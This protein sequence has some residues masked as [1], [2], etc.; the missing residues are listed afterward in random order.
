M[1]KIIYRWAPIMLLGIVLGFFVLS[2]THARS[3]GIQYR[4]DQ[5]DLSRSYTR[6]DCGKVNIASMSI[7]VPALIQDLHL[8][9]LLAYLTKLQLDGGDRYES[10][11]ST[12]SG[13]CFATCP[14]S[15]SNLKIQLGET[16]L[17]V[18]TSSGASCS[19]YR[20]IPI[21]I[22]VMQSYSCFYKS[23]TYTDRN[24]KFYFDGCTG[25]GSIEFALPPILNLRGSV[26]Y[27]IELMGKQ[28]GVPPSSIPC[29]T[30]IRTK[31]PSNE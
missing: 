31:S 4:I 22:T 29:G 13:V 6:S 28:F 2:S 19:Q 21:S 20:R 16:C 9:S 23:R 5:I 10:Y 18:F 7:T 11:Q 27:H 15:L 12:G 17:D 25:R 24:G 8:P 30:T 26:Q 1:R 3:Q 14:I